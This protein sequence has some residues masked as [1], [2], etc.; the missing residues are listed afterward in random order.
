MKLHILVFHG[1]KKT[2]PCT[3]VQRHTTMFCSSPSLGTM[4]DA[5][6][7]GGEFVRPDHGEGDRTYLKEAD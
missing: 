2:K 4:H 5:S 6:M 3:K 7:V 1:E